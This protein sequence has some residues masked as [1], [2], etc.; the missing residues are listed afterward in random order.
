MRKP[1]KVSRKNVLS[2]FQYR[3]V[4]TFLGTFLSH[5]NPQDIKIIFEL[6]IENPNPQRSSIVWY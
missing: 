4:G 5:V 3:S 1:I 6:N 2:C